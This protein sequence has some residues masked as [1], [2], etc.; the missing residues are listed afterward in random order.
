MSPHERRR[1]PFNAGRQNPGPSNV[2][3]GD[4]SVLHEHASTQ[5]FGLGSNIIGPNALH[6]NPWSFQQPATPFTTDDSSIDPAILQ[7]Q[8]SMEQEQEQWR[9][10]VDLASPN[11]HDAPNYQMDVPSTQNVWHTHQ[12]HPPGQD[13]ASMSIGNDQSGNW[14]MPSTTYNDRIYSSMQR[15]GHL[16]RAEM[17]ADSQATQDASIFSNSNFHH[18]PSIGSGQLDMDGV[19]IPLLS[20]GQSEP[21]SAYNPPYRLDETPLTDW[22][23]TPERTPSTTDQDESGSGYINEYR[24]PL[25]STGYV[26]N[27]MVDSSVT[28][29]PAP[30][31]SSNMNPSPYSPV[32]SSG[33]YIG[34]DNGYCM[35]P[36]DTTSTTEGLL[37]CGD[38]LAVPL[39]R[40]HST[41]SCTSNASS[42][43]GPPPTYTPDTMYCEVVNCGQSFTG[44]YRRGNLGR[45]R[46]LI[47]GTGRAYTCENDMCAKEFRRQDA[48]LKHYRKY[49]PELA[50][51]SPIIRRSSASRPTRR[52]Q[53]VEFSNMSSWAT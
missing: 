3:H 13:S 27:S 17:M 26:E 24:T 44:L 33:P 48:R 15:P 23:N 40:S 22:Q 50:A 29:R 53:E 37:Q 30:Q 31:Y 32:S 41:R 16:Q 11:D 1:R 47:H 39:E 10:R 19:N 12:I 25:S 8:G 52:N 36:V 35:P 4:Q 21:W 45:H 6:H 42:S 28:E 38:N 14:M 9:I 46:R 2:G 7:Q 34:V 43:G 18:S 49:H 5:G 20:V 51:D